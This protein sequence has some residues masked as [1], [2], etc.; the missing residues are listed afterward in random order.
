MRRH[1]DVRFIFTGLKHLS[2]MNPEALSS[3]N[4]HGL[5]PLDLAYRAT[6]RGAC[7][8]ERVINFLWEAAAEQAES[9]MQQA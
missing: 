1:D 6:S 9:V 2:I 7:V 8:D 4:F 3:R 5:T